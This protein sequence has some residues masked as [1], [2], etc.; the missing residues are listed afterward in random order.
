MTRCAK[1][2]PLKERLLT[3][4]KIDPETGCWNWT[5]CKNR[6]GYGTINIDNRSTLAHR[7]S[8]ATYRGPVSRRI[9][10]LHRC[11]NPECINPDHLFLGTQKENVADKV[12]KGRQ[13]R[14]KLTADDISAIRAARGTFQRQ[15]ARQYGVTQALIS[16]I[17][18]GKLWVNTMP[19]H[20]DPSARKGQNP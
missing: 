14:F 11:D 19:V 5:G 13:A 9:K 16:R 15:L 12:A 20:T 17:L 4:I 10:V 8:Y 18:S 2:T 7:A 6:G 3:K 1:F